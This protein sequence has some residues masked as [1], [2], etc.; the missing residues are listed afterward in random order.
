[1]IHRR[2][3]FTLILAALVL[4]G[5]SKKSTAP[6][7]QPE[8]SQDGSVL[9]MAW[10]EQPSISFVIDDPGTPSNTLDDE[11]SSVSVDF[12]ADSSGVRTASLDASPA[13]Q[14][15]AYSVGNDGRVH[16][17]FDFLLQ[18]EVR[19]IGRGVDLYSF[20]DFHPQPAPRY[21]MR[22][23]VDGVVTTQSPVSNAATAGGF[24]DD[25]AW[26][27]PSKLAPNDSTLKIAY[28]DDPRAVFDVVQVGNS[29]AV[30]GSGS[31]FSAERRLRGIPSPAL[32]GL[33]SLAT[34]T[35]ILPA[36]FGNIRIPLTSRFWPLFFY[37][38]V[39]AFDA[40]GQMVN[41]VN[42]YLVTTS[43]DA[44]HNF[45]VFEPLGGA[46]QVIDPY[47]DFNHPIPVPIM[48]TRDA[49]LGILQGFEG[50]DRPAS[51]SY[52]NGSAGSPSAGAL[53][54]QIDAQVRANAT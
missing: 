15:Q 52:L 37:F 36:G 21:Y 16:P 23:A 22:G 8:G 32:P 51:V 4:A 41:R 28:A 30:L 9:L 44:G 13:N 1:M 24:S 11:L 38:R 6:P 14:M 18:P 39:T 53:D 35:F 45:F 10:H 54:P 25:M 27:V 48:L 12:W 2:F 19:F 7:S 17:L 46:V 3:R 43:S 31:T 42:D 49:A 29:G 26:Q 40:N 47:P 33:R 34:S 5:C 20:E 50:S